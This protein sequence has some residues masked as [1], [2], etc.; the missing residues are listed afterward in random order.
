MQSWD[1][2]F[3][4]LRLNFIDKNI[5]KISLWCQKYFFKNKSKFEK[6]MTNKSKP[7]HHNIAHTLIKIY[8]VTKNFIRN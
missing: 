5:K 8:K 3:N 6:K 2:N 7:I 1:L 4:V